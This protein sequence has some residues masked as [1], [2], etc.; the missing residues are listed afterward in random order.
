MCISYEE[1]VYSAEHNPPDLF[2]IDIR[3]YGE[4]SGIDLTSYLAEHSIIPYIFL[5]SQYDSEI[6]EKPLPPHPLAMS[7]SL[8]I[9]KPCDY[10]RSS[11]QSRKKSKV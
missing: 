1:A 3:L 4:K 9:K 11:S 2:I 6:V 8:L 5:T 7:P 10:G